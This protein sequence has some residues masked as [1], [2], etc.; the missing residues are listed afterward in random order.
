MDDFMNEVYVSTIIRNPKTRSPA[1]MANFSEHVRVEMRKITPDDICRADELFNDLIRFLYIKRH[2]NNVSPPFLIDMAWRVLLLMPK[3]YC[4]VCGYIGRNG[5]DGPFTAQHVIDHDYLGSTG[6]DAGQRLVRYKRTLQKF[7]EFFPS[8]SMTLSIVWNEDL[9][10][11]L[12]NHSSGAIVAAPIAAVA[13]PDAE[14]GAASAM[15]AT[16]G[17]GRRSTTENATMPIFVKELTGRTVTLNVCPNYTIETVKRVLQDKLGV[18]SNDQRLIFSG[19]QLEDAKTLAQYNIQRES[20]LHMV[21]R[22]RGC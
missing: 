22:L 7:H 12:M 16:E 2:E 20:T 8:S 3:F 4:E 6:S 11:R 17:T 21:R 15:S 10:N 19:L 14:V 5:E 1:D 18:S 13:M 9:L